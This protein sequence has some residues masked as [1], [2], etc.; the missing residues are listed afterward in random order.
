MPETLLEPADL[1]RFL[2]A[3]DEADKPGLKAPSICHAL[4]RGD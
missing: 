2:Q 3:L 1:A 4:V